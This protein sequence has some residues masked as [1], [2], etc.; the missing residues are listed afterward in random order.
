M[1]SA[2][3]AF[4]L[5]ENAV[6]R[7]RPAYD[8]YRAAWREV[9]RQMRARLAESQ[10]HM[11][12][13]IAVALK[14]QLPQ[15]SREPEFLELVREFGLGPVVDDDVDPAEWLHRLK[16]GSRSTAPLE[17]INLR[18]AMERVG[19]VLEVLAEAFIA[20]RRGYEQFGE[21]M[22]VDVEEEKNALTAATT[23]REVLQ[24]LLDWNADGS[25]M[26]EDLR[27]AFAQVAMHQVA[28]LYGV[29]EGVRDLLREISPSALASGRSSL[30]GNRPSWPSKGRL[31]KIYEDV[32][33]A[34]T[35]ED[36]FTRV[37]FGR[38]FHRA[39]ISVT[40]GTGDHLMQDNTTE[41][42][43]GG[44]FPAPR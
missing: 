22:A 23:H 12:E 33:K 28:H 21:D 8:G 4:R 5:V 25:Q 7:I 43:K 31:W 35:D 11:R 14:S 9:L 16:Q 6:Q 44:T 20:L 40:G 39:Y 34:L 32:H 27:R 1:Q 18:L 24:A 15:I 38:S 19:A 36:H 13:A 17:S 10:P 37:V 26:V 2:P 41:R 42:K 29:V 3:D 30:I